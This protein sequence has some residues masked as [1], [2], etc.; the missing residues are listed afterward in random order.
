[1]E[2]L[3][4]IWRLIFSEHL[5]FVETVR[6]R[7]VSKR[8]KFLIDQL[9]PTDLLV[10][11]RMNPNF[12]GNSYRDDR[13]SSNWIQLNRLELVPDSSFQ[14]VFASLRVL[15]LNIE[16]N[17][18][19]KK[20]FSLEVLNEFH[21]LEKLYMNK[22]VISRNQTLHLP[23]LQVF[24]I[25]LYSEEESK[26]LQIRWN[27]RIDYSKQPRLF[28]DSKVKRLLCRRTKLLV[29][30]HPEYIEEFECNDRKLEKDVEFFKNLRVLHSRLTE[31][32]L[33]AFENLQ[34]LEEFHVLSLDKENLLKRLIAKRAALGRE[35]KIYFLDVC[36]L[37]LDTSIDIQIYGEPL[38]VR[39]QNYNRLAE[40]VREIKQIRYQNLID[41]LDTELKPE[42]E[43]QLNECRFP[44]DFFEKFVNIENVSV[45]SNTVMQWR[46]GI[47]KDEERFLWFLSRCSRLTKLSFEREL[48]TQSI[49][50]RL[51][52]VCR[53]LKVF[54]IARAND[55]YGPRL[56]SLDLRPVYK[57][58]Q[59]FV[60]RIDSKDASLDS[61]LD[62][63][64]LFESC[65]YLMSV[66]LSYI[67]IEK[68]TLYLVFTP[69][70]AD[71]TLN[72]ERGAFSYANFKRNLGKIIEECKELREQHPQNP[73]W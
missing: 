62:L 72:Q 30:L 9:R 6:C 69:S 15:E 52:E 7:Q 54:T 70:Q 63:L 32:T 19:G 8:F 10:Y 55:H 73:I 29:I 20:E 46:S 37:P 34:N 25:D 41:C 66:T 50:N 1:M 17:M 23:N 26:E 64:V 21:G 14:I 65:R 59:L 57:L 27:I 24:S 33:T 2:L 18:S 49:V 40:C 71:L 53:Q 13:N 39:I 44:V 43:V 61:P 48:L 12:L 47:V 60:L 31:S 36:F 68:R 45:G 11:G 38:K 42:H 3:D 22:V 16:L 28:L 5:D 35:V 56:S 51:P 58:K 4:E 67:H